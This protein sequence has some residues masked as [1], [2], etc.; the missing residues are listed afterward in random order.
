MSD[1]LPLP[2]RLAILYLMLPVCIWLAGWFE[3]WLGLPAVALLGA[4]LWSALAGSLR[5]SRPRPAV[6]ACALLALGWVMLTAAGGVF[7]SGNGD[8]HAHRATLLDLGRQPW[9]VFLPDVVSDYMPSESNP[10]ARPLLRYYLGWYMVPG[11]AARVGGPAAL[12][13]AVPLWTWL[14]V[15]L[16]LLLFVRRF[17]GRGA[18]WTA[19]TIFVFFSGMDFLRG[20]W[21]CFFDETIRCIHIE[22]D[23]LWWTPTQLS[24]HMT[25]LM[26]VP[27]HFI[28]AGL[29]TLLLLHLRRRPRFLAVS[30]VVLAASG[31]WSPFVAIGLL[32][33]VAI[34][35]WENGPRS[36]LR[37]PNLCLA[38]P[39]AALVA[40]YLMSGSLDYPSGWMWQQYDAVLLALKIP[41][42]YLTEFGALALLL[43]VLRPELRR[44]PFFVAGVATL[45]LLP[46]V[47]FGRYN[48]LLMRGGMPALLVLC[49]Y[50][51][52]VIARDGREIAYA[53]PNFRRFALAGMIV[54]L[55]VGAL[56]PG[57]EL[58]R[59]LGRDQ[60]FRY[61]ERPGYTTSALPIRI[62]HE[63]TAREIPDL[64]RRLLRKADAGTRVSVRRPGDSND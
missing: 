34:L 36:F 7:D 63:R 6:F 21:G 3:W 2:H 53:G 50:C 24:S 49:Y 42:V 32:P 64:L 26:W 16:V 8:W 28:P 11:L 17:R 20:N 62:Q 59:A 57:I 19:A 22:W 45:L 47:F 60:G 43:L 58:A 15:A 54:V 55:C 30:G 10:V 33:L 40:L 39:L 29:Y 14:G 4:G 27:Q 13:W 41:A 37:W 48:N 35:L 5:G 12:N 23:R 18:L 31:F 1:R 44:E 61:D 52:D 51:A 46:W 38:G 25:G 56:T 9:P